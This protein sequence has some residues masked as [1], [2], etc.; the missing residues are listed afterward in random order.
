MPNDRFDFLELDSPTAARL[1][2]QDTAAW[3]PPATETAALSPL[4]GPLHARV[5]TVIGSAGA[6]V[7]QFNTPGGLC[8][9]AQGNLYVADSYNHRI[10]KIDPDGG[11]YALGRRGDRPGQFLNPQGVAVDSAGAIY[12]VE[13]G[14]HRVQR[15]QADGTLLKCFGLCGESAGQFRFPSGIAVDS[16]HR[17][18]IAD[19]GNGRIQVFTA[20]GEFVCLIKDGFSSPQGLAVADDHSLLVADTGNHRVVV[21]TPDG[22]IGQV[23]GHPGRS[24]GEWDEPQDLACGSNGWLFV[25]EMGNHRL[26]CLYRGRPCAAF[27]A[28]DGGLTLCAPMGVAARG[29]GRVVVADTLN[30]RL[31]ELELHTADGV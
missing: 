19:T 15:F 11:V 17:I 12:V 20:E 4:S 16:F 1:Q 30:H 28:F 27:H 8:A 21:V 25:V 3:R 29:E 22:R 5:R 31:L 14:N 7:G 9:D 2:R 6:A 13:Q 24:L 18:Y 26:Q 10:Q 23:I